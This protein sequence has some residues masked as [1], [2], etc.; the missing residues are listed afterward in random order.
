MDLEQL[1]EKVK[2][3][4][5]KLQLQTD[6]EQIKK[7]QRKYGYHI[8]GYFFDPGMKDEVINL[9]SD[10]AEYV[11]VSDLGKFLGKEGVKKFFEMEGQPRPEGKLAIILQLQ[12]VVDVNPDGKTAKG[13]W[14]GI[15]IMNIT[16]KGKYEPC[17]GLGT[18][19]NEYLKENGE[20]KFKK[21]H[22]NIIFRST[23]KNGWVKEPDIC[24]VPWENREVKGD[25]PP[26]AYNPYPTGYFVPLHWINLKNKE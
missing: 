14:T 5:A 13:R 9:F 1:T 3:L 16:Q 23:L 11:E 17:L 6:I 15:M 20:W 26:S 10:N 25:L 12:G 21:L 24:H 4:E 22:W 19:E 8:Y 2:E 18:Y 7:L